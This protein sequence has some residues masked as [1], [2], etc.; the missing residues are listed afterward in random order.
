MIKKFLAVVICFLMIINSGFVYASDYNAMK[1]AFSLYRW[2]DLDRL[3]R[4]DSSFFDLLWGECTIKI[5]E[6][7]K[8]RDIDKNLLGVHILTDTFY[9]YKKGAI[10]ES[11]QDVANK[12]YDVPIFRMGS[13]GN[14][15]NA[16]KMPED[17]EVSYIL[18]DIGYEEYEPGIDYSKSGVNLS[19]SPQVPEKIL[20][21]LMNNP[22]AKFI[23]TIDIKRTYPSETVDFL[24]FCTDENGTSK[25][26]KLRENWGIENP[27][28]VLGLEMGNE[29]YFM[30]EEYWTDEEHMQLAIEWYIS[31]C[32]SHAEAIEYEFP[33][34]K[35]IPSIDGTPTRS[36]FETWNVPVITSLA[37]YI[38]YIAVHKYYTISASI[39]KVNPSFDRIKEIIKSTGRDIKIAL[40]EHSTWDADGENRLPMKRQSLGALLD[41]MKFMCA[42]L[43]Q[44]EFYC[45]NYHNFI[46]ETGW[47]MIR[48][49]N[50]TNGVPVISAIG[51]GFTMLNENYG[52]SVLLHTVENGSAYTDMNNVNNNLACVVMGKEDGTIKVMLV[53]DSNTRKF[54]I[55]FE[56]ENEY[57]LTKV[58]KITAPNEYS[59][60]YGSEASDLF[61]IQNTNFSDNNTFTSY[62][63]PSCSF[64]I[65]TLEAK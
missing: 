61:E 44:E 7:A 64:V 60:I 26:A 40:T 3:V 35:I 29:L 16:L 48:A 54:G 23:F 10:K 19:N 51:K 41:V 5:D 13:L 36:G 17:R 31:T 34:I 1:N 21:A 14:A 42:L 12:M 11:Y 63:V 28:E 24:H 32:I 65:L 22:D 59:Y 43:P 27:I 4:E 52:D 62:I 2:S 33:D 57:K 37:P 8:V 18:D 25:W 30:D 55:N 56:L 53:N 6:T 46:D 50:G 45:A 9:D 39:F 20:A 38:D 15:V 49:G 58:S 47:G